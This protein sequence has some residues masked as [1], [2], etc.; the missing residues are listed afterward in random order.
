MDKKTRETRLRKLA[1]TRLGN[2]G[3]FLDATW[4]R[5]DILWGRLDAAEI[6]IQQLLPA[7]ATDQ[8]GEVR[9][10]LIRRAQIE[11]LKE[12]LIPL[13]DAYGRRVLVEAFLHTENKFL[14]PLALTEMLD[15]LA[16]HLAPHSGLTSL[17]ARREVMHCYQNAY[18]KDRELA[19]PTSYRLAARAVKIFGRLLEGVSGPASGLT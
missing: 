6:L 12:E 19:A 18:D 2:F 16:P 8:E 7:P 11:I 4:R 9:D 1:G 13:G 14:D 15:R 5:S 17:L 10:S 3:A